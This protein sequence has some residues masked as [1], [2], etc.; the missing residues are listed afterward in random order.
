MVV[1]V[2]LEDYKPARASVVSGSFCKRED[3]VPV[4][5]DR[6]ELDQILQVYGRK[7]VA[8]EWR[9]YALSFEFHCASFAV[10]AR[11]NK[12]P[13]YR[14]VKWQNPTHKRGAY[15][16][17]SPGGR[18]LSWGRELAQVLKLFEGRRLLLA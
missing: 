4:V 12:V 6:H 1:V 2:S 7:V 15:S 11:A 14:I 18:I 8:G 16:V 5:F 13:Q 17:V 9:D 3:P 10:I